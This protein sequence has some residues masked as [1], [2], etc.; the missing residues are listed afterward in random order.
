DIFFVLSGF[1]IGKLILDKKRCANFF[2]VFY[3]RRFLR[4]VPSYILTLAA[5]ATVLA[6]TPPAW[7]DDDHLVPL[8][9]Y[10]VFLQLFPM[11]LHDTVGAHWLAPTWT[12]AVEEHFYLVIPSLIVFTPRRYLV[13]V[14]LAAVPVALALRVA[15]FQ[16]HVLP[17]M[18]GLLML[19]CRFDML[20]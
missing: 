10:F 15:I 20:V 16:Y 18:W 12:L 5:S 14:L 19:P 7:A 1:L 13:N 17:S 3:V 4:I 8:W 11:A 6:F 2:E 9:T